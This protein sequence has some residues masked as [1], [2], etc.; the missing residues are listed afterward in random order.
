MSDAPEKTPEERPQDTAADPP[1]AANASFEVLT[2]FPEIIDAATDIG[3][4]GRARREGRLVVTARQ[5]RDY[6]GGGPGMVMRPEPIFAAVEDASER[7]PGV[8]RIL[9]T[10]QGRPF[11]QAAARRLAALGRPLLLFCARYEGIDERARELFDEE[12]SIGDYVLTGGELAALVV[13][14]AVGRLVPGVLGSD[15]SA[16]EESFSQPD[17]LEYPQYTR[18]AE[19]RGKAVPSVLTS[20]NHAAVERWRREEA[21][22]RT[23]ARRP[24]L[25]R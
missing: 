4:I 1:P 17:L 18:P 19:F 20:G 15:T 6:T 3:V 9:M 14:D 2:L 16:T 13:I 5:L 11:D 7:L 22:K 10:P 8:H 25:A 21:R 24:D 12:L 23:L